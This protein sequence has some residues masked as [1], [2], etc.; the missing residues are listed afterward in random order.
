MV[1]LTDRKLLN[2]GRMALGAFHQAID[3]GEVEKSTLE[4]AKVRASQINGCAVC[5]TTHWKV[6]LE[7]GERVDRLATVDV[8]RECDWFTPREKAALAWSE[9]LTRC[10]DGHVS[11]K[12][13]EAV[14]AEF[15]EAEVVCLTWT[16]ISINSWNRINVAFGTQPTT[17]EVPT[18]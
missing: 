13:Y 9:A 1:R 15:S 6:A 7:L 3:T 14:R 4:L 11:D 16:I 5:L 17:F 12:D 8:W 18:P 10:A 2:D